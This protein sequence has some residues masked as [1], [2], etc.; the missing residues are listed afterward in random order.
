MAEIDDE[1]RADLAR[2]T[3]AAVVEVAAAEPGGDLGSPWWPSADGLIHHLGRH[4]GWVSSALRSV[5][6]PPRGTG[7]GEG[8]PLAEWFEA[9]RDAYTALVNSLDPEQPAWTFVGP[10]RASFWFRRSIF[11]VARHVW[12]LR[13]AG[14]ATPAAPAE[15]SA[16]RY[17]DGV[18]EHFDVFL[19]R[20]RATLDPLPGTLVLDASDASAQW[21]IY[22]DWRISDEIPDDATVV[23]ASAGDLALLCW[24]RADPFAASDRFAVS[25]PSETLRAFTAAPIHR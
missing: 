2:I 14:G 22:D 15:L 6:E 1:R 23:T 13:T 8:Q 19:N 5:D 12:D 11:E 10:G 25:G 20:S 4:F 16:Q 21:A 24:E 17:A 7:P 3:A 18:T 9:E